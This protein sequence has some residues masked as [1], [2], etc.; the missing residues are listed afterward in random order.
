MQAIFEEVRKRCSAAT[1]SR[2]VELTRA[3]AVTGVRADADEIVVRVSTK[4]GLICPTVTLFLDD[5]DWECT[6]GERACEHAAAAVIALRRAREAGQDLPMP[7]FESSHVGYRLS[8]AGGAIALD[9]ALVRG[10]AEKPIEATLAAVVSGRT[11]GPAFTA[12]PEDLSIELT[13]GTHRRGPVPPG[14]WAKLLPLLARCPDVLLDGKPVLASREPV[15]PVGRVE[16]Q[17]DGFRLSVR[18]DPTVTEA[19]HNGVALCG[20]LLR[21]VSETKLTGRELYELPG[22]RYIPA[23]AVSELVTEVLPSLRSRIPVEIATSRLPDTS[24]EIPR[25]VLD[26]RRDGITLSVLPTLV[27]GDPPRAR[28]DAGRL[29]PLSA[30]PVPLRDLKAEQRLVRQ[31]QSRLGL[32]P[33]VRGE[34]AGEDAVA[35]AARIRAWEGGV[36]GDAHESF[37]VVAPIV[38]RL[39]IEG[40][41]FDVFFESP[42]GGERNAAA[43]PT[44]SDVLRAWRTGGSLVPLLDGGFAPIP[45]D[46]LA[47]HGHLV[48]DLLAARDAAGRLPRARAPRSR[49][50]L[51]RPRGRDAARPRRAAT[52]ARGVR[53]RPRR[54]APGGP[55]RR[56]SA[57]ISARAS[58]GSSSCA[59]PGSARCSPTTW[60]SARRCRRSAPLEGRT[61]VVCPTSVLHNWADEIRRFRP[62]LRHA[63]YHGPGRRLDPEADVTLTTYAILRL[64]DEAL[65]AEPWDTAI[66]D[67]AQNIKN[68][69][70]Q[71]DRRRVALERRG[72]AS[73]SPAPP[74]RT[75]SRSSGARS[76]SSTAGSS[77]G[78]GLRGA[79]RAARSPTAT[80]GAAERLRR[81][82]RPFVLRRLKREVAPELPPRSEASCTASMEAEERAVYDAVRAAT[83]PEVV[84]A[85]RAGGSVIAALEALLRLRQAAC[86]PALVPGP[87]ARGPRRRSTRCSKRSTP[88]SP[89]ATRR[90][91]SRSGR[92]SS[93]WS[94]RTFGTQ[95]FASPASTAR[96]ATAGDVVRGSRTKPGRR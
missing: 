77:A 35:F 27:Y 7:E 1:W 13:L 16:D 57:P 93:T 5:P 10:G 69:R 24:V 65:A 46:W 9:R 40:E 38:P 21:P 22:G 37:R 78:A 39:L 90:S 50:A 12:S 75:A 32:S 28:V 30:G 95:S 33:G 71:V 62:G 82:I 61:L 52:L 31:V 89:T 3:D 84:E 8:R 45:A 42:E 79:L 15:G 86:H 25:V 44:R 63:V 96:R 72:S 59:A 54:G 17:G 81:R 70:S 41:L 20:D 4:G 74:S 68:P 18:H 34:F 55:R 11:A 67:E 29:V 66:L 49:A 80:P 23:D 19:F 26:V 43:A 6:C 88:S 56:R 36:R 87:V 73:R 60:A 48:A 53:A 83:L 76:T 64:D 58:T 91:S 85:L 14:L 51:R 47:R 2:G 94:S 92:R